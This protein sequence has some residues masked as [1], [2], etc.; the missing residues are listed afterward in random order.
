MR[1]SRCRWLGLAGALAVATPAAALWPS[2]LP[3]NPDVESHRLAPLRAVV[4]PAPFD[5]QR[6]EQGL[7]KTSA[8]GAFTKLS[9]AGE[10]NRLHQ[11]LDAHHSGRGGASLQELEERYDLLINKILLLIQDKDTA[12]AAELAAAREPMWATLSSAD[13]FRAL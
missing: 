9:L 7:R 6:L 12:L 10:A 4:S 13:G 8:V 2:A 3:L 5:P 1:R 11:A